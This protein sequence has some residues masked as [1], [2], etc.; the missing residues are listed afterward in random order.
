[1]V[2]RF[3]LLAGLT[4]TEAE[5]YAVLCGDAMEQIARRAVKTDGAAE[6]VLCAAAAA[7]ALYRWALA[8][9]AAEP[10]E[11]TAG[12]VKIG[13]GGVSP[14]AAKEMWEQAAAAAAPCLRDENFW[15]GGTP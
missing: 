4:D 6:N 10:Q 14:A 15:F 3:A 12:S 5:K 8:R 1:M 7:L 9:A 2:R 13:W 11:F